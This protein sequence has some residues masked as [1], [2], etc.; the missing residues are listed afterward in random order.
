M[1]TVNALVKFGIVSTLLAVAGCGTM[2]T[3]ATETEDALCETWRDSLPS[4]SRSDSSQ[5]KQEIGRQ[6]EDFLAACPG[7]DLPF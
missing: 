6:Y 3:V 4:R 7:R 5:T 2:M 1:R